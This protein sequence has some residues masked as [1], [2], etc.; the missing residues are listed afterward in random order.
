MAKTLI[1]PPAT[2]GYYPLPLAGNGFTLLLTTLNQQ[3]HYK[4]TPKPD[5]YLQATKVGFDYGLLTLKVVVGVDSP[6]KMVYIGLAHG[7]LQVTCN[8]GT[9]THFLSEY[10]YMALRHLMNFGHEVD[11]TCYNWFDFFEPGQKRSKYLDVIC[12]RLGL[13]IAL[14]AKYLT[15]WTP[16]TALVALAAAPV[17]EP[18]LNAPPLALPV[19]KNALAFGY[20]LADPCFVNGQCIHL[21]FLLPYLGIFNRAGTGVKAFKCLLGV[22]D[23][24]GV[25]LTERQVELNAIAFN[26]ADIARKPHF[27]LRPGTKRMD[28]AEQPDLDTLQLVFKCWHHALPLLQ[29][30]PYLRFYLSGHIQPGYARP[31]WRNTAACNILFEVP[32]LCFSWRDKGA[33]YELRLRFKVGE[34]VFDPYMYAPV[35]FIRPATMPENFYLLDSLQD[36]DLVRFFYGYGYG[37]SILKVHEEW[38]EVFLEGLKAGYEFL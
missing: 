12:D 37:L 25:E 5:A 38:F 2:L 9:D 6:F 15:F 18:R 27:K 36:V 28:S 20:L 21:P 32:K 22:N 29:G 30:Q 16:G 35:F 33:Y 17:K 7:A 4:Y 11:L 24:A 3:S 34:V 31:K 23:S 26:M 10:A 14:K 13:T 8:A 19:L 1:L